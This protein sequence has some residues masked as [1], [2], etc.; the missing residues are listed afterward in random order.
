MMMEELVAILDGESLSCVIESGGVVR[1]F[2]QR[3]VADLYQL[4]V[5][6]PEFLRGAMVADKVV[7]KGAAAFMVLY[8]VR[9]L[10]T[11]TVS[12]GAYSLLFDGGVELRC[13]RIV[14][15]IINR[16]GDG[17]CPV[18]MLCRE[19]NDPKE[20]EIIVTKFINNAN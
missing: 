7:G 5:E 12:E 16:A 15:H 18:E 1:R 13:E 20:I 19:C 9:E 17:W 2:T 10:F 4:S 11:H 14:P 8:G 6:E 3:G